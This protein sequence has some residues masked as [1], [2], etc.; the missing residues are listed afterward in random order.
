MFLDK[1]SKQIVNR[2]ID[3][4]TGAIRYMGNDD[5]V[6]NRLIKTRNEQDIS[7]DDGYHFS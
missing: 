7:A 2:I 4:N 6:L 3:E 1:I 5:E